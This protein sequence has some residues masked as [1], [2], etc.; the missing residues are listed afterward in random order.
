MILLTAGLRRSRSRTRAAL[1]RRYAGLVASGGKA[2][3]EVSGHIAATEIWWPD[4]DLHLFVTLHF[5]AGM[6][7]CML[8]QAELAV[9]MRTMKPLSAHPASLPIRVRM[10]S[11]CIC[12]NGPTAFSERS[13]SSP[14]SRKSTIT[15]AD[16]TSR[17]IYRNNRRLRDPAEP[18]IA[19]FFGYFKRQTPRQIKHERE[20][21]SVSSRGAPKPFDDCRS[22]GPSE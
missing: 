12:R 22:L 1:F 7:R 20:F 17:F 21:R 5:C 19:N 10:R 8:A 4:R 6:T 2:E 3:H 13:N 16:Q 9:S 15:R 18:P 11:V 14:D